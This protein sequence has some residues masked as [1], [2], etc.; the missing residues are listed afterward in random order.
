M[1]TK[2]NGYAWM[3]RNKRHVVNAGFKEEDHKI[4]AHAAEGTGRSVTQ[5]VIQAAV[6]AAKKYSAKN[7]PAPLT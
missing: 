7:P 3:K 1:N 6:D 5:F 2:H 4:V